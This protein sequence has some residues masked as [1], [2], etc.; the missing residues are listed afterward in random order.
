[1]TKQFY[2]SFTEARTFVQ[3]LKIK[4]NFEWERYA[5]SD[6]RPIDIPINPRKTYSFPVWRGLKDF[7]GP[8]YNYDRIDYRDFKSAREFTRSLKLIGNLAWRKYCKSGNKPHNIPRDPYKIYK[9]EYK[10]LD[11][12]L[13]YKYVRKDILPFYN[14]RQFMKSL[15]LKSY[16]EWR[17][18]C[19]SGQKPSNIPNYPSN[20]YKDWC[21][22]PYWLGYI[23]G[24]DYRDFQEAR[25][26][27][28]TL[29][30]SNTRQWQAYCKSG[31]KPI[32][33][34]SKPHI[35][36]IYKHRWI[37]WVDWL[38]EP[39]K[40]SNIAEVIKKYL[41]IENKK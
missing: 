33:I 25:R 6:N 19:L 9:Q 23:R 20:F 29:G 31:K 16:K 40:K 39:P 34:P 1:M 28:R 24:G 30:F 8:Q 13:D 3:G 11:D 36:K 41:I 14:A 15:G 18:Y 32:D 37:N 2:R 10:G 17:L 4:N 22:Y 27:A 7:F 21:G 12:W 26:F 38:I 35:V 5:S